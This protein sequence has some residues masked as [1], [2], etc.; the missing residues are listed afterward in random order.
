MGRDGRIYC[1]GCVVY[2]LVPIG[3]IMDF[4]VLFIITARIVRRTPIVLIISRF[5]GPLRYP[6][7]HPYF[8]IVGLSAF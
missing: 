5:V 2:L 1:C 8:N 6:W 3:V 7:F 4:L